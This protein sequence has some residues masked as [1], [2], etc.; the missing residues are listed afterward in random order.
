MC[1]TGKTLLVDTFAGTGGMDPE[2]VELHWMKVPSLDLAT[3]Y[4]I[5]AQALCGRWIEPDEPLAQAATTSGTTVHSVSCARCDILH[6]RNA[7]AA[8]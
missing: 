2:L 8:P 3:E 7:L 6:A 5:S 1:E 4:G